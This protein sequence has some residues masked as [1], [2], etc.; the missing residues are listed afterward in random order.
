LDDDIHGSNI[1][2]RLGCKWNVFVCGERILE[3]GGRKWPKKN[4]RKI[5]PVKPVIKPVL[6]ASRRKRL[7][8]RR[9]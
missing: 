5:Q 2:E 3:E 6:A 9:N 1:L 4:V 7:M 8:L